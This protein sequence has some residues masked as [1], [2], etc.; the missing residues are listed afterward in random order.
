MIIWVRDRLLPL[1][2]AF[3]S[4]ARTRRQALVRDVTRLELVSSRDHNLVVEKTRSRSRGS[5][6]NQGGAGSAPDVDDRRSS[7][8]A[9]H[10]RDL[11]E[12]RSI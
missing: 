2:T 5:S 3:D 8:G 9:A 11:L 7:P 10:H 4:N 12:R 1:E 6:L